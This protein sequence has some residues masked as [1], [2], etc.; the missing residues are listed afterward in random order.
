MKSSFLQILE[1]DEDYIIIFAN[2]IWY[3]LSL[4][5][6]TNT[7]FGKTNETDASYYSLSFFEIDENND[8][9]YTFG[10]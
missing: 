6:N 4:D 8:I 5:I 1:K 9:F 3:G 10:Y 7:T 2:D